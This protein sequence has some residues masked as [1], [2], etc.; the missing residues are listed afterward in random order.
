M[1]LLLKKGASSC[2]CDGN[3][4]EVTASWWIVELNFFITVNAIIHINPILK[5]WVTIEKHL[6]DDDKRRDDNDDD[7]A[8]AWWPFKPLKLLPVAGNVIVT[9]GGLQ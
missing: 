1:T 2:S 5:N 6:E 8:V 7:D 4:G 3:C 9:G